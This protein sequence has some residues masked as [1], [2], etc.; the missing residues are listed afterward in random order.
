VQT[1]EITAEGTRA[2]KADTWDWETVLRPSLLTVY[3]VVPER[4]ELNTL[5]DNIQ[6]LGNQKTSRFEIAFW[7]KLFY[8]AAVMVMMVLAMPFAISAPRRHR[9]RISPV[10]CRTCTSSSSADYFESG[11]HQRLA[12]AV[13]GGVP[14]RRFGVAIA[15]LWWLERR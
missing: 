4:L 15:M 8:P 13:F 2:S 12:T 7:N 11:D 14:A 1:T 6:V 5:Y 9:F 3:Q 10:R